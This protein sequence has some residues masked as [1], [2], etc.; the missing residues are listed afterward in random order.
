MQI[1]N[2]AI[3]YEHLN[4]WNITVK[5]GWVVLRDEKKKWCR[6][7]VWWAYLSGG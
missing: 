5:T 2:I 7:L 3:I 6:D 1:A 4:F